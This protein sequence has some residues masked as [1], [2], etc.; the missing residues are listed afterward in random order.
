MTTIKEI[1]DALYNYAIATTGKA[2][3][4]TTAE[5]APDLPYGEI[6]MMSIT[7]IGTPTGTQAEV[8]PDDMSSQADALYLSTYQFMMIGDGARQAILDL[9]NRVNLEQYSKFLKDEGVGFI[10]FSGI[11]DL[12][13]LDFDKVRE[14]AV[15]EFNFNVV[16]SANET[17][18]I[19]KTIAI[20]YEGEK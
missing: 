18:P 14:R 11:K 1:E 3:V 4:H 9:I 2:W 19:I 8:R 5:S 15:T 6:K 17:V 12:T 13:G 7:Q 16:L 20:A 10:S